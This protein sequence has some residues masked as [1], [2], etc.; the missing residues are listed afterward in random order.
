MA[1]RK[2]VGILFGYSEGWIG[3]AYYFINLVQA[4]KQLDDAQRPHVVIITNNEESYQKMQETGYPYLSFLQGSFHYSVAERILNKISRT[5]F[6]KNLIVKG[7][8][9]QDLPLLFGYYEQLPNY[10]CD[11]KLFWIPD[12]Q[13][14]HYPE[15]LGDE[16]AAKRKK[17]HLAL[18][19]SDANVVFS[20]IDAAEDF[21][22]FYSGATCKK[23]VVPFAVTLPDISDLNAC[24][25]LSKYNIPAQYFFAPNQFWSHKNHLTVVKAVEQLRETNSEVCV[26][27][28]GNENTGGGKYAQQLKDYVEKKGLNKNIRFL[29]FIDRREQLV[30]MKQSTVVIQPSMFEG[31]STVIEDA[32][33]LNKRILAS[34]L[35]VHMEQLKD[36]GNAIF[37]EAQNAIQL[38]DLMAGTTKNTDV[39]YYNYDANI[40]GYATR[41]M[42]VVNKL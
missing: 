6:R 3:G 41:F 26:V 21:L 10:K 40:R 22:H 2:K 13:D 18:G 35:N 17:Q 33:A 9:K 16:V 1:E 29:G 36:N 14:C 23:H 30:L 37:F 24:D 19:Y 39:F 12:L 28:T 25:V 7:H 34:N 32:K 4:F 8:K 31:W 20:S 38:A 27:F 5:V 42:E 11:K 15:Y